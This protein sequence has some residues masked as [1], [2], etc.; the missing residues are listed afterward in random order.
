MTIATRAYM[1]IKFGEK[2]LDKLLLVGHVSGDKE[3]Y[4][5]TR[6]DQ[7]IVEGD[8]AVLEHIPS[9]SVALTSPSV[10]GYANSMAYYTLL[11]ASPTRMDEAWHDE[12][13]RIEKRLFRISQNDLLT[14]GSP[15]GLRVR[16]SQSVA[17]Q[18][19]FSREGLRGY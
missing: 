16:P 17:S 2:E 3:V 15:E 7:A 14:N 6:A 13:E 12:V 1:E 8:G 5:T 19:T 10:I 4:K 11:V 18:S 9:G